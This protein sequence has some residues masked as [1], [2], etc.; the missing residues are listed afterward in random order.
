M[1]RR[2]WSAL[3][4]GVCL[5][6]LVGMG[7][8]WAVAEQGADPGQAA[9]A[10]GQEAAGSTTALAEE[11]VPEIEVEVV[12]KREGLLSISPA[13]GERVVEVTAEEISDQGATTVMEAID[14]TPSVFIRHQGARYENR[15]S[16]RGAAPRLV[17]LDGIPIAREG[18]SG[19][20]GGAGGAESAF[21]GRILYTMPAEIIQRIDVIRSVGTIVYGPTSATG[22]VINI[23]T[24]EP[25][26]D[27]QA[28]VR[29]SYG[30]YDQARHQLLAGLKE[31]RVGFLVQAGTDY[32]TSHL[33]FGEKRFGNL[34]TK[35]VVDQPDGS[36][37][38][39]DYFSLDG[40]RVLDLSQDFTIVPPRYW[41]IN[42][43]E[44][45]FANLVYSK[46]L[47]EEATLD[48]VGYTRD[49]A[50]TSHLYSDATFSR[51]RQDW[52]EGQDD[53]G[54][55]LRY[56]LRRA[57]GRMT[58]AGL[59]YAKTVSETVQSTYWTAKGGWLPKPQVSRLLNDRKTKGAFVHETIPVRTNLRVS[60]GAR[61]DKITDYSGDFTY[62]AG[63]EAAVSPRT[64]WHAHMGTGAEHPTPTAG[65]IQRG[66]VLADAHTLSLETGWTVRPDEGSRVEVALFWSKTR[67]AQILY[68]DPPGEIGP[69]AWISKAEDLTTHGAEITYDRVLREGMR[70]FANCAFLRERTGNENPPSIP[71]PDYPLSPSVPKLILAGG[72]RGD[73]GQTRAA[74]SARYTSEYLALNRMMR[75]AA[76]VDTS[77]VFELTLSRHVGRGELAVRVDNLLN[78]DYETMP[79]FPRPG[80]NYL[81]SYRLDF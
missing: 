8:G 3:L 50:F 43:W 61:Y 1:G 72:V 49:R 65:D 74:L 56:S 10:E 70:W 47:G 41:D 35:L 25:E 13:P 78:T 60:L 57:N 53:D 81:V 34:F 73:V 51:V 52:V 67:D 75:T 28:S 66:A 80:R 33:P 63:L 18:Y 19:Q 55:D 69:T 62:S 27:R 71:G 12:G 37:L 26:K 36:K 21:A 20:G 59:Q 54:F 46:A 44:E 24:K 48:L 31:E 77:L 23:V 29:A 38:L 64:T 30:S 17:L 22:A 14:L 68:N 7:T 16:I 45:K 42:P 9:A 58:R 32:A 76:P 2:R 11:E 39:L 15:L 40:R 79:A 6:V 5:V 4:V